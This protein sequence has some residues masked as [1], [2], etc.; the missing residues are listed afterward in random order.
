MFRIVSFAIL[1]LAASAGNAAD[2]SKVDRSIRSEPKYTSKPEYCLVVFGPEATERVWLV[3]DGDTLYVDK[4]G[5]GDLTESG[6]KYQGEKDSWSTTFQAGTIRIGKS[7]HRNLVVRAQ[8]L[9]KYGPEVTELPVAAAALKR[10]RDTEFMAVSAEVE[11]PGLKGGG[12]EG[13]AAYFARIDSEGPLLFGASPKE[14]P[15][16]HFGGPLSIRPE[17]AKPI[18]FRGV[19]HDL[20]LT[21]GTRGLGAGTF[22]SVAYSKLIPDSA[23]VVVE[24]EFPGPKADDPPMHAKFELRERC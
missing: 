5:N 18:L 11:V 10:N 4:T 3:R 21:V 12:D 20:M 6:K 17:A 24:A 13:R 9:S 19:P 23:Y 15:I 1:L 14:A 22:A 7:E 8:Q 16:L 2:L